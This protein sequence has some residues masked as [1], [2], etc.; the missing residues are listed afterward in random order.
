LVGATLDEEDLNLL[1]SKVREKEDE[2][3]RYRD[4][5]AKL[6]RKK[7]LELL[8]KEGWGDKDDDGNATGNGDVGNGKIKAKNGK[9][10]KKGVSFGGGKSEPTGGDKAN[11]GKATSND[12]ESIGINAK[13]IIS[14]KSVNADAE[15][16]SSEAADNDAGERKVSSQKRSNASSNDRKM[17]IPRK[18]KKLTNS[19]T[20]SLLALLPTQTP[21]TAKKK[22]EKSLPEEEKEL[23]D[24]SQERDRLGKELKEGEKLEIAAVELRRKIFGSRI[25][26]RTDVGDLGKDVKS[27]KRVFPCGGVMVR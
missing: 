7:Q 5:K 9:P 17:E 14:K 20:G 25:V 11:G 16:K 18:K 12:G 22:V 10:K 6:G 19:G 2:C 23:A 21:E 3:R 15:K 13:S 24:P 27:L 8:E 1:R 26:S 4:Y